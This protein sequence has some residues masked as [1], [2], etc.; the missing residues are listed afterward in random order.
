MMILIF[1]FDFDFGF[2]YNQDRPMQTPQEP[3]V[4]PVKK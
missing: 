3:R 2:D 1:D 4:T